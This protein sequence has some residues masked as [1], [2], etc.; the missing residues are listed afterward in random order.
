MLTSRRGL[1]ADGAAELVAELAELGAEAPSRPC[2]VADR[3]ALAELLGSR[4]RRLT[5]RGARGRCAGRRR[6]RRADARAA[7]HGAG[8][9]G[10]RGWHLH[11]LTRDL[12]LAAFVL[13]SSV[14]R[15]CSA[16][17]GQGNYA[18]ANAFLDAL[19]A[20]RRADGLPAAVAGL[21]P[22]GRGG[23][24]TGT[25]PTPTGAPGAA[26]H[27]RADARSE[28][29]ALFD[30][31]LARRT[32]A[33]VVPVPA[34]PGRAARR[35]PASVPALLRGL[36]RAGVAAHG[37]RAPA[38]RGGCGGWP[39]LPGERAPSCSTWC[40]ARS[41]P[42]SATP[43][44][45]A[46]DP[47]AAFNDLGFDSLTAVELRNRL[48]AATGL[49]LPATLVFDYPTPRA[50]AALPAQT[51]CSAATAN[52]D[53]GDAALPPVHRRADRDRWHGLPLSRRRAHRRR[54]CG[55][56]VRERRAT[57]SRSSRP[58]AAGTSTRCTT[59]SRRAPGKTYTRAGGFLHGAAEFDAGFFGISPREALA[60]DPQQRLLLETSWEA[61]ER[62][63]IEPASLRGS[64]PACSPG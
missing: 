32:G 6:D 40:A 7:G 27:G 12:D 57:R 17:P 28:G 56:L 18:A 49:R 9:E 55:E 61:L 44:A 38:R 31:A 10:R 30:A 24:M 54:S 45:D 23:G 19:A 5:A 16:A 36:V 42:C 20:H 63:G 39:R 35:R 52:R 1:D 3:D 2:D 33:L 59:L 21:G 15:R 22:V 53:R 29:L 64:T 37:A 4:T 58:T 46:V 14:G 60:M 51:S 50:L 43:S 8:A 62:A 34:G 41:P 25:S 47:S 11:E 26:G 13:F 48:T